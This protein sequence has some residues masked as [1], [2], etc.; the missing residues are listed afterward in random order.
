MD[1]LFKKVPKNPYPC[2]IFVDFSGKL[3]ASNSQGVASFYNSLAIDA[4][5]FEIYSGK[6]SIGFDEASSDTIAGTVYSQKLQIRFPSNDA[7]RAVRLEYLRKAKFIAVK[8]TDNRYLVIGRND[9]L[10]NQKPKLATESN[11][12][13]TQVSFE[14][15]SIFPAAFLNNDVNGIIIDENVYT[16]SLETNSELSGAVDGMNTTYITIS[17]FVPGS[18]RLF[19]NGIRQNLGTDYSESGSSGIEFTTAPLPTDILIIDYQTL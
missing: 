11:L 10:Q 1:V 5:W 13:L 19:R 16:I 4:M 18:T 2:K 12:Q 8:L 7:L 15:K 6:A 17:P 9:F 3:V 14:N